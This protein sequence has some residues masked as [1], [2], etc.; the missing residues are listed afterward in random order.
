MLYVHTTPFLVRYL[1]CAQLGHVWLD[2]QVLD[3]V[4][5]HDILVGFLVERHLQPIVLLEGD[6]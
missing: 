4:L 2:A 1:T 6:H 3:L 5:Q